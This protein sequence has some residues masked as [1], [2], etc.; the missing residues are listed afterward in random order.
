MN[1]VA[2]LAPAGAA[3]RCVANFVGLVFVTYTS[4]K[5]SELNTMES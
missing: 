1:A 3:L 5:P 4:K 2:S